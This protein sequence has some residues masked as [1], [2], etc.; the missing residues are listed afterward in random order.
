MAHTITIAVAAEVMDVWVLLFGQYQCA[1]VQAW[2][3]ALHCTP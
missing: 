2:P 1:P 3:T